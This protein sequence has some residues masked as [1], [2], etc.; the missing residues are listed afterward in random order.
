[1]AT[2]PEPQT[3]ALASMPQMQP[4]ESTSIAQIGY[5]GTSSRLYLRFREDGDIYVYYLVPRQVFQ[6][7]LESTSKG[8]FVN[9]EVK[10]HY[11]YD[12]LPRDDT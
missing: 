9:T 7:L 2:E 4:V 12:K 6:A 10:P 1:M 3:S 5:D 8:R 11:P